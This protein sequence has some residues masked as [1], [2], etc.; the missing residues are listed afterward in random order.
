[1]M[2]YLSSD[3][4]KALF[5]FSLEYQYN[6]GSAA[7]Y[8]ALSTDFMKRDCVERLEEV[9]KSIPVLVYNG[10]NDLIVTS[11]GTMRWVNKLKYDGIEKFQ[12]K[13]FEVWKLNDKVV[14]YFKYEGNLELAMVNN[15]GHLV[16]MDQPAVALDLVKKFVSHHL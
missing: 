8:E 12:K 6:Q 10:Q 5:G 3:E 11:S 14:G 9:L 13:D 16:P 7:V 1:M 15:A 2:E 4:T